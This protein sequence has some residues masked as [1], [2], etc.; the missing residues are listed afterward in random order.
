MPN[1][2]NDRAV[3]HVRFDGRSLDVELDGF[4]RQAPALYV[5]AFD[6]IAYP[7]ECTGADLAAWEKALNGITAGGGTSVGV[8]LETMRRKQ[9]YVE[10]IIVVTDEEENTAPLFVETL[11][12]YREEVKA[13]PNVCFVRTPGGQ[14]LLEDQCRAAGMQADGF[15]FTGDYYALP[16]RPS[17]RWRLAHQEVRP[18]MVRPAGALGG[19]GSVRAAVG[20]WL[21]RRFALPSG[22]RIGPWEGEARS[23]PP[24][25][26]GSPGGSPSQLG[27]ES[28]RGRARLVPSRRWRLAH[29]EVRPP[30]LASGSVLFSSLPGGRGSC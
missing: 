9:Q 30:W 16:N 23:E 14:T 5:Y 13:D 22:P 1:L 4:E 6:T 29:Q 2:L 12:K 10:Q 27:R 8:A 3:L 24:L 7:V 21:A 18:P 19:R 26:A 11:K 25:A 17:R 20:G 28:G 15:Q